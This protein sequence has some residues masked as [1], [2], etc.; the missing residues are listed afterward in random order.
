M[1]FSTDLLLSTDPLYYRDVD[2][3]AHLPKRLLVPLNLPMLW[4]GV[5]S[6]LVDIAVSGGV[7]PVVCS[8]TIVKN[9]NGTWRLNKVLFEFWL[10]QIAGGGLSATPLNSNARCL[11]SNGFKFGKQ[12]LSTISTL[13]MVSL[14]A[15]RMCHNTPVY[16]S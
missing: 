13:P 12:L 15:F 16:H 9:I 2:V 5:D 11:A 3:V 4:N 14:V 7:R 1:Q 8:V 6:L 10:H